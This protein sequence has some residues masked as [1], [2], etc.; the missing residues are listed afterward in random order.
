[1]KSL[2]QLCDDHIKILT[3]EQIAYIFLQL[4]KLSY[5]MSEINGI[6]IYLDLT[7]DNIFISL[8][9]KTIDLQS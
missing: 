8:P 5:E 3:L 4:V 9:Q 2:R 1:M 7:L 6:F